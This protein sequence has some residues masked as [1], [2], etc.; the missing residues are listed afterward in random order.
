MY[1][2]D[3]DS[4]QLRAHMKMLQT[5]PGWYHPLDDRLFKEILDLDKKIAKL[6]K[7]ISDYGWEQESQRQ[8]YMEQDRDQYGWK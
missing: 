3:M 7:R 6:E 5:L 4:A 8:R 1:V 2:E